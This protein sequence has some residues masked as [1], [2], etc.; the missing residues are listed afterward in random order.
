ME[1]ENLPRKEKRSEISNSASGEEE[2][3][4]G[5][6]RGGE[7]GGEGGGRTVQYGGAVRCTQRTEVHCSE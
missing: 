4:Q 6:W 7:E 3:R 1:D 5:K 2:E